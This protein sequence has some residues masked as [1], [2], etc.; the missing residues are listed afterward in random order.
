MS[1]DYLIRHCAPTLARI[2]TGNLFTCPYETRNG[3]MTAIRQLNRRLGRKGICVLPLRFSDHKALIYLFRP[4]QLSADLADKTATELLKRCG[5]S[6][7]KCPACLARLARK[8]RTQPDFPHE[9]GLFLGYPPEDV[10]GFMD[11]GPDCCKCTG[12]WK[13]YSNEE[14]AK[15]KF[16]QYKK[17]TRVYR[18]CWA[19]G[20]NIE[21]LTVAG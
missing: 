15:K 3:L 20:M 12:C 16:A 1:E 11:C 4:K 6:S 18:E 21:R 2:K 14:A 7:N 8:L 13:V 5:Y 17:C 9:I 10:R 19:K